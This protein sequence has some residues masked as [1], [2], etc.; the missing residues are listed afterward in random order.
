MYGCE[1][2]IPRGEFPQQSAGSDEIAPIDRFCFA[3]P[4]DRIAL[5]GKVKEQHKIVDPSSLQICKSNPLEVG[6]PLAQ[7]YSQ[8]VQ[9]LCGCKLVLKPVS[10]AGTPLPHGRGFL[11]G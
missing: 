4:L 3:A 1:L 6:G 5:N 2:L 7:V 11:L 8:R 10:P 9:N